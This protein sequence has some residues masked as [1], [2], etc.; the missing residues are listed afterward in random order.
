MKWSPILHGV[1]AFTGIAGAGVVILWWVT[2]ARIDGLSSML[3]PEH[4]YDDARILFLASIAFGIGAL[5]H[6]KLEKR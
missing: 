5:I 3:T 4:M 6:M 1:A 2:L